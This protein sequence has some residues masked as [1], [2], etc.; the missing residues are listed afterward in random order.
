MAFGFVEIG[1]PVLLSPATSSCS[2]IAAY[3]KI[4]ILFSARMIAQEKRVRI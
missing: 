2:T 1:I 4:P 3:M